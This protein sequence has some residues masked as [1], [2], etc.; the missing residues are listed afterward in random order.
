MIEM[1]DG[2]FRFDGNVRGDTI[3]S[4]TTK[5]TNAEGS[6]ILT[7][8]RGLILKG[9][10]VVHDDLQVNISSVRLPASGSPTWTAY[11]D[12]FVLAFDPEQDNIIY[13]AAQLPHKYQD[14]SDIDF[15]LHVVYPDSN[16]GNTIWNFTY[17]WANINEDF[18]AATTLAQVSFAAS[19][20]ADKHTI[21]E[22]TTIKPSGNSKTLSSIL[23]CSLE[24]EGSFE[25]DDYE[26]NIYLVALDFH[27]KLD[28][29]GSKEEYSN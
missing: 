8:D 9:A 28:K 10:A 27:V 11:K 20:D 24:R 12:S 1:G 7:P 3:Q 18:P 4:K 19:R 16:A 23:L 21:H 15:H 5:A 29:L 6:S 22:F 26:S 14:N 13:F 2:D 17:S 25:E